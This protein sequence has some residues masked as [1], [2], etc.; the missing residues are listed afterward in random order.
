MSLATMNQRFGREHGNDRSEPAGK[1]R[2]LH[3]S[4]PSNTVVVDAITG[5]LFMP[6]PTTSAI[7]APPVVITS[8]IWRPTSKLMVPGS[9]VT[10]NV[11]RGA[12]VLA[13]NTCDVPAPRSGGRAPN[14]DGEV[15]WG[16]STTVVPPL[17]DIEKPPWRP[18]ISE[19]HFR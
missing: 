3:R 15:E 8:I 1:R 14:R 16:G 10:A 4:P 11:L 17:S 18:L 2:M 9:E 7:R 13:R 12:N 19:V 6:S 5:I